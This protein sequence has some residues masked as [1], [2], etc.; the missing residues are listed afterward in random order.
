MFVVEAVDVIVGD[1][2]EM[3]IGGEA[4]VELLGELLPRA[5]GSDEPEQRVHEPG[6]A[7]R[8]A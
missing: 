8:G 1:E 5:I 2:P 6:L 4:L 3:P 7:G